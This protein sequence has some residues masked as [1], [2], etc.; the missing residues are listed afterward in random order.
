[1]TAAAMPGRDATRRTAPP[2][3]ADD[4]RITGVEVLII[5]TGTPYGSVLEDGERA[6]PQHLTIVRVSTDAGLVGHAD[7]DSHPWVVKAI[8]EAPEHIPAFCAGLRDAVVGCSVWD[9]H[10]LWDRMYRHSWYH[11]RAGAALHAMSGIDLAVW[12]IA[13]QAARRPVADLLGGRRRERIRA[14]ASTLFRET[15]EQMRE[16]VRAYLGHGFTAIKFGWG[17][18]GTDPARDRDLLAAARD[19]AGPD[20]DLMVDG[21]L[22]GDLHAITR[23]LRGLEDLRPRWV[24]EAL[25]ADR[26]RD[27]AALGRATGVRIATG[28]QLSHLN[29]FGELLAE[30]GVSVLQPDLSRCGGYTALQRIAE[31]ARERGVSVIPHAWSSH[32]LTAS[33]LQAAAWLPDEPLIEFNV[34]SSPLVSGLVGGALELA[35]GHVTVPTGPG[36]GVRVDT[37]LLEEHRVA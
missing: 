16:A 22:T 34:S 26:P 30:P 35:E 29:E 20:V 3:G 19:E 32:L 28:E 31:L 37:A 12:D 10:G 25:P 27:L 36:L 6:G 14:Y 11:G 8:V 17:P 2:A 18:W 15:P 9:R 7:V 4:V 24:E 5:D 21:H 33:T 23:H 13:G 1:M